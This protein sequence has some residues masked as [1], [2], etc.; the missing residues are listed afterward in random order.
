MT[1]RKKLNP[2]MFSIVGFLP[3]IIF[4]SCFLFIPYGADLTTAQGDYY[5]GKLT[6]SFIQVGIL[7]D[8][9]RFWF[10]RYKT[11]KKIV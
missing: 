6:A 9:V 10:R 11:N 3:A 8:A 1:F 2:F 4:L 7:I 5:L